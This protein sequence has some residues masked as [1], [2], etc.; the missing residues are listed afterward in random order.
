MCVILVSC[1]YPE[2]YNPLLEPRGRA[3][4]G[5]EVIIPAGRIA[6]ADSVRAEAWLILSDGT[7]APA[8]GVAWESLSAE[9]LSVDGAGIVYGKAPGRG[10]IRAVRGGMCATGELEVE[11]SVDYGRIRIS[12]VFYDA[13]G[14]DEGREFIE[15]CNGNEYPCDLSGMLLLDGSASS[16]A[17]AIPDGTLVPAGG[18]AVIASSREGFYALFGGYPDCAGL[19]FTL[20]NGGEAVRLLKKDG[21]PVDAV[22]I[23]GGTADFPAPV[24]WCASGLPAASSGDSIQRTADPGS[25]T[26]ADWLGGPPTPGH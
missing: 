3:A 23:S 17:F 16:S 8:D 2:E 12:E 26:C 24:G 18:R 10:T 5:L 15:L 19:P 21:S 9:V 7:K 14:S 11:R 13:A 6:E 1:A 4:F 22:Y 25:G 20:N